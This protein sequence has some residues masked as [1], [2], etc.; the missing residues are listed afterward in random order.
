MQH[1]YR[2]KWIENIKRVSCEYKYTFDGKNVS[3]INGGIIVI[4]NV[5]MKMENI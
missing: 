2:Y 4:S 1:D 5:I 3:Q